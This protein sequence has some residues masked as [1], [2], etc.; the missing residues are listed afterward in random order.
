MSDSS[1]SSARSPFPQAAAQGCVNAEPACHSEQV[2]I[3]SER[4]RV[5]TVGGRM[6]NLD[7]VGR[8]TG[9]FY[10]YDR[11]S[12]TAPLRG[13]ARNDTYPAVLP[14][15]RQIVVPTGRGATH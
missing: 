11:D 13:S 14:F 7:C 10:R 8:E 6:R 4:S 12:S 5:P 2:V 9:P 3:P 1:A 15:I